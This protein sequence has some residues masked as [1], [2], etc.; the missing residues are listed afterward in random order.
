MD[1]VLI[2]C[3]NPEFLGILKEGL[4]K[5]EGQFEVLTASG[6]EEAIEVLKREHVSVLVTD[7]VMPRVDGP[8]LLT[9][10]TKKHPT[11]PCIVMKEHGN[12][13]IKK[14]ADRKDVFRYFEKPFDCNQL[15]RAIIEGLDCLDEGNLFR[16]GHW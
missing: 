14:R 10:M 4:Q 5:Y 3:D 16:Q 12:P 1:K 2:V 7:L 9:H 11:T 13:E 15:A 6:G 8:E